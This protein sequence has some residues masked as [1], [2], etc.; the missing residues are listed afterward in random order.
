MF[1]TV[2]Y[3]MRFGADHLEGSCGVWKYRV[4][5]GSVGVGLTTFQI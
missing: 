1:W 2:Y 5:T 3:Q 4:V